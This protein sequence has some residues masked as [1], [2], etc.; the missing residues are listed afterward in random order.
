MSETRQSIIAFLNDKLN[1]V[2]SILL[3]ENKLV[4]TSNTEPIN[5]L[6]ASFDQNKI[7]RSFI[8]GILEISPKYSYNFDY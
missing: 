3:I 6:Q 1:I 5:Q 2:L 7:I 8:R 4:L